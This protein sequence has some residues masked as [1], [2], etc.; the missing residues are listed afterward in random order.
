MCV[1]LIP[2]EVQKMTY[3]LG[4]RMIWNLHTTDWRTQ[5]LAERFFEKT[6]GRFICTVAWATS[7][8]H[9][10]S[11]NEMNAWR[12]HWLMGQSCLLLSCQ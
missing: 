3:E 2:L 10:S 1:G 7:I 11:F 5:Q 4:R 8:A 9:A 12:R 6:Q